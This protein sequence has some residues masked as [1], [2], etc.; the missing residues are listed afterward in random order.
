LF[1]DIIEDKHN[2]RGPTLRRHIR[3]MIS[4]AESINTKYVM[5]Q[6]RD[7]HRLQRF[8]SAIVEAAELI[9]KKA[10]MALG[11]IEDIWQKLLRTREIDFISGMRLNE[12]DKVLQRL[13]ELASEFR[14]G[15][16]ELDR[17][18]IVPARG[19]L[20]MIGGAAGRGK[21]WGLIHIGKQAILNRQK[22]VHISCEI[23]EEEVV[24][25]YYQSMFSIAKRPDDV[26]IT[27]LEQDADGKIEGFNRKTF[28]PD[29]AL[30]SGTARLELQSHI[31]YIGKRSEYL[32]VKRFKPNELTGNGLRAYLDTLETTEGFIPDMIIMDYLG[33]MKIDL[34]DKR[35]SIGMNCVELRAVG[36]E[37]N[38]AMV[39]AHQLSK[40][41]EQAQM[42]KGTHFA[43]D[44]SI[45]GTADIVLVFSVT[46]LEFRYGLARIYVAKA[47]SEEDRFAILITQA[48]KIGQ[49][50][51]ESMYLAKQ[52]RD[53]LA[54]LGAGSDD[55]DA[56]DDGAEDEADD[57][58]D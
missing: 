38:A 17:R 47:R 22:V 25:R 11:E 37:R 19:K 33:L 18:G 23:D 34:K 27:E 50:C 53:L 4:L 43:E 24:A 45:M 57:G 6:L 7:H 5:Q 55:Y 49:F 30:G 36:I 35:G 39:T 8:K 48:Y 58:E 26:E 3:A 52:Y 15:I 21:T 44:W 42:A 54:D 51:L 31:E 46:D 1:A 2:R 9:N 12:M 28:T 20:M 41:G 40:A 56:D 29:W 32:V 14:C 16:T 13:A 10:H